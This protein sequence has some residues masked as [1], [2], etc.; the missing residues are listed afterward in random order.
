MFVSMR[1]VLRVNYV[2]QLETSKAVRLDCFKELLQMHHNEKPQKPEEKPHLELQQL[3]D[4][5]YLLTV[6]I[7]QIFT[8]FPF[9]SRP[10]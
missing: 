7:A 9:S 3:L 8:T 6:Q 5:S 10:L 4:T 2:P 1:A